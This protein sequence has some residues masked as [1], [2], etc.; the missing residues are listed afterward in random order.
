[1]KVHF[2]FAPPLIKTK[3]API[4]EA[5]LPPLGI[6]YLAAYLRKVLPS[7][8][9]K[10]TDGLLHGMDKTLAEIRSFQPDVL[11][12][13]FYTGS[14]L[15]AYK[16]INKVNK[17]YPETVTIV[18]GPHATA[19]PE[20]VLS[21]SATDVV[22][23]GEGECT[24]A[25]LVGLLLDE[26]KLTV[27]VLADVDGVAFR[28]HDGLVRVTRNPK[29]VLDLD[30]IPFPAWHLLRLSD[31]RGYHLCKQT[32]EY[33]VLFS[34]GC[35]YD[36]V[37]CPNE[38]WNLSKP[39][40]RFRTPKNIVDEMEELSHTYGI[41]E[42]NNLADELNNHPRLDLEICQEITHRRLGITWKTMLRADNVRDEL[43]RAMAESGCWLA[44]LGI[45]TG[46]PA[47]MVGIRKQFTHEQVE[48]ACRLFKKYGLKVQGYFML[49]NVWEEHGELRFEDI[50]MSRNTVRCAERLFDEGLLDYMGWS[51]ATPY[52]GSELY[53]IAVRHGLIRPELVR[54]WDDWNQSAFFVMKLPDVD[55]LEQAQVL[56]SAQT[57]GAKASLL[58]RGV[59]L[60]DIPMMGRTALRTLRTE[61]GAALHR[62]IPSLGSW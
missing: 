31:Y 51:V 14:A 32:P 53:W 56:R 50:E 57:L 41:R 6:L 46:N 13:S 38:H 45:E 49:F 18:G 11:C 4:W 21:H 24:L 15:G 7:V 62:S 34:R 44:S 22:V 12:V 23:R 5:A 40:V 55:E 20:D 47:T 52:P 43:V 16:L 30:G 25:T 1:M 10:A 61:L 39:K 28:D 54:E 36:C 27:D 59:R 35:P 19:L 17:E 3:I 9:L 2:V 37:F 48:R 60:V 8:K 42:F 26:G 58:R 33:P 29:Y